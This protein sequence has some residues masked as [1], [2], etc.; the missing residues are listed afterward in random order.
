M[1][2]SRD[3]WRWKNNARNIYNKAIRD[4]VI[5]RQ[6]ICSRCG[7]SGV[8][9]HGHHPDYEL[10]IVVIWLCQPCHIKEHVRMRKAARRHWSTWSA[11]INGVNVLARSLAALIT[12]QNRADKS[13]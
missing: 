2:D 3:T 11:N 8:R 9:I 6:R 1:A 13:T 5:I 10:P 7:I 12:K 4:G